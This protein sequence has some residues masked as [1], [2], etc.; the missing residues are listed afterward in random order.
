MNHTSVASPSRRAFLTRSEGDKPRVALNDLCLALN[1]IHCEICR[2]VC[3]ADA[4]RFLPRLGAM[5]IPHFDTA[6]CT[7]CGECVR[8]CPQNAIRVRPLAASNG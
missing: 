7:Q 4:L 2:D 5:S 1:A 8:V 6:L 3:E